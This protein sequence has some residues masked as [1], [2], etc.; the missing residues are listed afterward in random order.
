MKKNALLLAILMFITILTGCGGGG[1]GS[2]DSI[3]VSGDATLTSEITDLLKALANAFVKENA[4]ALANC[5]DFPFTLQND[6]NG[7][8]KTYTN[9][10]ALVADFE[11]SDDADI[12]IDIQKYHISNAHFQDNGDGTGL[13]TYNVYIYLKIPGY[14]SGAENDEIE[15]SVKNVDGKWK[16]TKYHV[17]TAVLVSG[18]K[19]LPKS[20]NPNIF[21]SVDAVNEK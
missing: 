12:V 17:L 15:L 9:Y 7:M 13:V 11:F 21:G 5:V 19:S 14:G 10:D 3:N 16:A 20:L 6:Y 1:G 8:K 2:E 18:Y 4:V